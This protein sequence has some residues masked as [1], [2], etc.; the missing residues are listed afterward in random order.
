[1]HITVTQYL[2]IFVLSLSLARSSKSF[3]GLVEQLKQASA[4]SVIMRTAYVLCAGIALL[5]DFFCSA[6]A[7]DFVVLLAKV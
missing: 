4:N 6:K 1:M 3:L 2:A 7:I 5:P